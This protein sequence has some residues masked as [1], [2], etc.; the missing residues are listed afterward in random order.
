AKAVAADDVLILVQSRN[1]LFREIIRAL[2]Q[3][4]LPTP[5]AD[6]LAVTTHIAVLDLLALGDVV[7]N[8]ADDLQ[9]AALLRSP[10]F[11]ISEDDLFT[12][13]HDRPGTLWSA[14]EQS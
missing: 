10:L 12:L 1:A 4:G 6:R 14:L 11:R 3:E 2:V 9:L 8:P 13:A 7:L 5:G